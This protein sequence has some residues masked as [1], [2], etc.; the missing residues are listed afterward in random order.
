MQKTFAALIFAWGLA[1]LPAQAAEEESLRVLLS[2]IPAQYVQPVSVA[3]VAVYFLK[4]IDQV[5]KNLRIGNDRDKISLY[6][7]GMPVKS[8]YKPQDDNDAAAWADLSGEIMD[9]AFARSDTARNR[10]FEAVDLMMKAAIGNFD[11]DSKYY[12]GL[13]KNDGRTVHRRNF[14]A[15]MEGDNLLLKI[16]AFNNFT[17]EEIVKAVAEHPQAKGLILDLRGSPGGQLGAAVEVAD[18]FLDEGIIASVRGRDAFEATYY[19]AEEGD[20]SGGKPMV[21]LIDGDTASAAEVLA[22]ALQ[23]Q[24]RAK[25][26]GT[27]SFG[28]G[29]IQNL[30]KL[31]NGGTVS[32]SSAY[33][34]TPA[35]RKLAGD[36]VVPDVCTYEMPEHKDA[37]RLIAAGLDTSCGREKRAE[38]TLEMEIAAQ[39]LK[40]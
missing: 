25:V 21:V 8:L 16:G 18:L 40:I 24:S 12:A 37:A 3:E 34:Y 14:G 19:N 5:D 11:N 17:K 1:A 32:L 30:I 27:R 15:R 28:K 20:I 23:E 13:E 7:R 33:F 35:E 4:N 9:L 6:Y 2:Q 29:T 39:L 31:P 26:A 36:G 10:D 38:S 22:A